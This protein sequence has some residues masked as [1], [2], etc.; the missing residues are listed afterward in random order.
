MLNVTNCQSNNKSTGLR[1]VSF[2]KK[3]KKFVAQLQGKFLGYFSDPQMAYNIY[4]KE[5]DAVAC[6]KALEE[7]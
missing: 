1:G 7:L 2:D 5:K 6:R 3:A 4:L